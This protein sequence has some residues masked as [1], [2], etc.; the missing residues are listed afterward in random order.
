ME[1]NPEPMRP[2]RRIKIPLLIIFFLVLVSSR[3]WEQFAVP[4]VWC[5][6]GEV[7]RGFSINGWREFLAP[8][9]GYLVLVPKAI[10]RVSLA[11]SLSYYPLVSTILA[12]FFSALAGLAVAISPTRLRGKLLCAISIFLVPSDTEVFGLPLYTLWWA[13]VLLLVVALWDETITTFGF[14]LVFVLAGGLSSPF[15]LI[16]LPVF[17]FRALW[18]RKSRSEIIVAFAATLVG[19]IQMYFV[20]K[21]ANM[22]FPPLASFFRYVIPRFCGWFL[23]GNFWENY[24]LLW[25]LGILVLMLIAGFWYSSRNR[26]SAWILVYLYFASVASSIFRIDPAAL[27]PFRGGPRYFFFPF[28]LTFWVLIQFAL[29]AEKKWVRNFVAIVCLIGFLNAIPVWSRHHDDLEWRAHVVSAR[30]FSVYDVPIQSDG[31]WF[32]AWSIELSG[33]NWDDQLRKDS[34]LSHDKLEGMRTFAYRVVSPR[35]TGGTK[36][37]SQWSSASGSDGDQSISTS[38]IGNRKEVTLRLSAGGRIRYR[39]GQAKASLSMEIVGYESVFIPELPM[40]T[41]WVTLEFSNSKL[42]QNFTVKIQDNGQGVG[43]WAEIPARP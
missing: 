35:D 8:L 26:V 22:G 25:P 31:H 23:W 21:G 19:A 15:I 1:N 6:D 18:Y 38:T 32:R 39:S 17:Y 34:F 14:R 20:L 3:R 13:P 40:T 16:L 43:E 27:H 33:N 2:I 11:V 4:Q 9:N 41:D 36:D 28:I 29:T 7:I 30:L 24:Y 5:E 37:T 10:T 12:C 42:P